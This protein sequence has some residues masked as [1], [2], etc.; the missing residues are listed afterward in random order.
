MGT[1]GT[2]LI[3]LTA[4]DRSLNQ[5]AGFQ[6]VKFS[7]K[8]TDFHGMLSLPTEKHYVYL[9]PSVFSWKPLSLGNYVGTSFFL[10]THYARTGF[11]LLTEIWKDE[12]QVATRSVGF[13]RWPNHRRSFRFTPLPRPPPPSHYTL[14]YF[15]PKCSLLRDP[16]A[17]SQ[18]TLV[19]CPNVH[20][21]FVNRAKPLPWQRNF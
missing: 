10:G 4:A 19:R 2:R 21:P 8:R 1:R 18:F 6:I 17:T 11:S 16:L 13:M 20:P 5:A 12:W 15:L 9:Q 3:V 14:Q 7:M